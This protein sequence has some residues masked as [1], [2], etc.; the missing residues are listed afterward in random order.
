M[1]CIQSMANILP[2]KLGEK[3]PAKIG[4]ISIY[5]TGYE[6]KNDRRTIR[7]GRSVLEYAVKRRTCSRS[8]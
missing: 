5:S 4:R 3:K 6:T 8:C 1:N 7:K 2:E